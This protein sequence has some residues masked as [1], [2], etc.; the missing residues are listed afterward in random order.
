MLLHEFP[1]RQIIQP[2]NQFFRIKR[3]SISEHNSDKMLQCCRYVQSI[4]C[5]ILPESGEDV[6]ACISFLPL[7]TGLCWRGASDYCHELCSPTSELSIG[8]HL[9]IIYITETEE[10]RL[11]Q[12]HALLI[13][14]DVSGQQ[15]VSSFRIMLSKNLVL[16]FDCLTLKTEVLR[17]SEASVAIYQSTQRHS[18]QDMNI[19]E[20]TP[21]REIQISQTFSYFQ[22]T[23][24]IFTLLSRL[25]AIIAVHN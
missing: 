8:L 9:I 15:S 5:S 3:F 21:L 25:T 14:N 16:F 18:A 17:F 12:C 7:I 19:Y 13:D 6:A 2:N 20:R 10:L 22:K 24:H 1:I 23:I 4:M 11:L